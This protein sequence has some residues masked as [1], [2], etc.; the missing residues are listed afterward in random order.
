MMI[1][2]AHRN[3]K[4]KNFLFQKKFL[5]KFFFVFQKFEFL[6]CCTSLARSSFIRYP[7]SRIYIY[8]YIF[9]LCIFFWCV[10]LLLA[11]SFLVKITESF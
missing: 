8:I 9:G 5:S 6:A 1:R 7:C 2:F 10:H 11:I 4:K 3:R